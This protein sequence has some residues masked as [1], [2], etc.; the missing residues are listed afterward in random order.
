MPC[1]VE[2]TSI[3]F[4]FYQRIVE[5]IGVMNNSSHP[6]NLTAVSIWKLYPNA[7]ALW[8]GMMAF[9]SVLG[10]ICN[11]TLLAT[12]LSSKKLRTGCGIL[13]AH[14]LFL[15]GTI[16]GVHMF[17][18]SISTV[19]LAPYHEL[20]PKFCRDTFWPYYIFITASIWNAV[21]IGVNRFIAIV[22]PLNYHY[23]SGKTGTGL[24]IL[25]I[26]LLGVLITLP[27]YI[28]IEGTLQ[29]S[30]PWG[31]CGTK[32]LNPVL[33]SWLSTSGNTCPLITLGGLYIVTFAIAFRR[34]MLQKR[35]VAREEGA[36]IERAVKPNAMLKRRMK[37]A[38]IMF[39]AYLWYTISF[40]PAP[41]TY[42]LFP[43]EYSTIPLLSLFLRTS[44]LLGYATVPVSCFYRRSLPHNTFA[45]QLVYV[46][47]NNDYQRQLKRIVAI[48]LQVLR[49]LQITPQLDHNKLSTT[50]N[51]FRRSAT[52]RHAD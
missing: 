48:F 43:V 47:L 46:G 45:F 31:S 49:S 29:S 17:I 28:G 42:A 5:L 37:S 22:F 8:F 13:I 14:E 6:V 50:G 30:K 36:E 11:F 24:I 9:L 25:V 32:V 15:D 35:K 18:L 23:V 1:C 20:S 16:S 3:V 10:G 27:N 41:L 34:Q 40:I 4:R 21:L 19:Y 2:C 39:R 26:W 12:I 38:K 33:H 51:T 44:L 52:S 7:L